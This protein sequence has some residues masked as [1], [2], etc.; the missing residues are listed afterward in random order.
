MA[1]GFP[2]SLDDFTNPSGS[3]PTDNPSASAT[4]S[5]LNDAIEAVQAKVGIDSSAVTTSHDYKLG[6]VTG[7][8]KAASLTGTETLTNKT[9]TSPT[10]TTAV[11]ATSLDMDGKKLIL[12]GDQD[13]SITADTDD[14]IDIEI[15]GADDFQFT[16]NDFTALSGSVIST[17]TINETTGANGV[18][19][20]SLNIKDAKLNTDDSVQPKHITTG[21]G[22]SWAWQD[23][24]PTLANLSGGTLTYADYIQ[25]GKTVHFRFRY[26]LAGAGVGTGPTFTLPVTPHADYV[27]NDIITGSVELVDTGTARFIGG[28]LINQTNDTADLVVYNAATA[29]LG[30]SSITATVP[31]TWAN[32]DV[33]SATGTYEAA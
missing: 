30:V 6:G 22:T 20:D 2:T 31:H 24:T 23:W 1:T 3:D 25:I 28:I 17:D 4:A 5:N 21:T 33:V 26:V 13:T 16:A 19:I 32:T 27:D 10:L 12:D 11:V 29:K 8:D 15:S 7:T 18:T 14:Q 9:L